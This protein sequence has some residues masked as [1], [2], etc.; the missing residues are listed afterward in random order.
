MSKT[1]QPKNTP[2]EK[3]FKELS[4]VFA[5]LIALRYNVKELNFGKNY[6]EFKDGDSI[7]RITFSNK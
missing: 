2:A 6:I 4:T 1:E 7:I 5:N 3:W